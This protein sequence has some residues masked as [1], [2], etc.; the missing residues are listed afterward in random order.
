MTST[1]GGDL[2]DL[3]SI[4]AALTTV[5]TVVDGIETHAH[6]TDAIVTDIHGTDLPAVLSAVGVVD[7]LVD[8]ISLNRARILQV[9]LDQHTDA[10][11]VVL[12]TVT[13][14]VLIESITIKT[15]T[16]HADLTSIVVSGGAGKVIDFIDALEGAAAN[17]NAADKQVAWMDSPVELGD[18]K[19]LVITFAGAAGA[20]HVTMTATI[21]YR[22][23]TLTGALA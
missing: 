1:Q 19:T 12:A 4:R 21:K 23:C 22:P 2:V 14:S 20:N 5:D 10:G 15:I 9:A 8:G 16:F 13:G 17:L 11:D 18:G 3:A 6:N 7:G